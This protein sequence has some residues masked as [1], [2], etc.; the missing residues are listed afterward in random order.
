MGHI[1]GAAPGDRPFNVLPSLAIL[2]CKDMSL[3]LLPSFLRLL[4]K[5]FSIR[6]GAIPGVHPGESIF[7]PLPSLKTALAL[8]TA[9]LMPQNQMESLF[10]R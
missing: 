5:Q 4:L 7:G 3:Q 2:F 9:G 10:F 6:E 1:L 8:D